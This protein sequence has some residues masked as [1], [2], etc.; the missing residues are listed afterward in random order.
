MGQPK[1]RTGLN[2]PVELPKWSPQKFEA[3]DQ[4]H[5]HTGREIV[6]EELNLKYVRI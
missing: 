2:F 3:L 5:S 6:P 1:N 4:T